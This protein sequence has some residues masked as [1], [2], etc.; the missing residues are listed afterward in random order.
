MAA[1]ATTID[2]RALAER[3]RVLRILGEQVPRLRQRGITR[4]SLF[5]S[6]ARG[7]AGPESDIDL[8]IE[9]DPKSQFGL[10]DLVDLSDALSEMLDRPVQFAFGSEMRRWLR[11]WIEE[12]RI[13]VFDGAKA[14]G[15]PDHQEDDRPPGYCQKS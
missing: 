12:D 14:G 5:G 1:E 4:L 13:E 15:R 6:V 8:L 11:E 10:R 7:E 9:I 3:D 2:A